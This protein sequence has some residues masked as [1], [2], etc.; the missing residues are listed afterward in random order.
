[1]DSSD[2]PNQISQT[3]YLSSERVGSSIE[4]SYMPNS[5]SEIITVKQRIS[6]LRKAIT[7][8]LASQKTLAIQLS[9]AELGLKKWQQRRE[10]VSSKGE[11]ALAI[12]AL[13]YED[14]HIK[15]VERLRS[16]IDQQSEKLEPLQA[17]LLPLEDALAKMM[18][19]RPPFNE[20]DAPAHA[21]I[22]STADSEATLTEEKEAIVDN[23]VL[24][25]MERLEQKL[26]QIKM[27]SQGA[28]R[29]L[30][31]LKRRI[32]SQQTAKLSATSELEIDAKLKELQKKLDAL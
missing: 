26:N 13:A 27:L 30:A 2:P 7:D 3:Q 6:L 19:T 23:G 29:D 21:P 31:E 4:D 17:E 16:E 15:L 32:H 14:E 1:M 11:M 22:R 9:I 20:T 10:L 5:S 18:A 25:T 12:E 8:V 24:K 28:S